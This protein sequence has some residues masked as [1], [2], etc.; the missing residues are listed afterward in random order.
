MGC[1]QKRV[2]GARDKRHVSRDSGF[3]GFCLEDEILQ[4]EPYSLV[5]PERDYL[6]IC[7]RYSKLYVVP[8]F[9]KVM[10]CNSISC[11]ISINCG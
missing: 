11:L 5:E 7:K 3:E 10:T 4:I 8:D 6:S 9:S 2:T 1:T